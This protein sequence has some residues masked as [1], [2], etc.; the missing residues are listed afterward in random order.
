MAG[1][2]ECPPLCGNIPIIQ[3]EIPG[4]NCLVIMSVKVFCKQL[5]FKRRPVVDHWNEYMKRCYTDGYGPGNRRTAY[6]TA[7]ISAGVRQTFKKESIYM[8]KELVSDETGSF[9]RR[10]MPQYEKYGSEIH[11]GSAWKKI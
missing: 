4:M 5:T 11:I 7:G 1:D 3:S 10:E 8:T 6:A 2:G 9:A